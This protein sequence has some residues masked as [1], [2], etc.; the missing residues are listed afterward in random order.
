MSSS[1]SMD[2]FLNRDGVLVRL[3]L[4]HKYLTASFCLFFFFNI[5]LFKRKYTVIQLHSVHSPRGSQAAD[6][7]FVP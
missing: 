7:L 3:G 4:L 6:G 5:L 1:F 2:T